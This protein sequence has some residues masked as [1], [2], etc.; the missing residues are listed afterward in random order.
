MS[1]EMPLATIHIDDVPSA[2][3]E[4][5]SNA[6]EDSSTFFKLQV[7]IVMREQPEDKDQRSLCADHS[8]K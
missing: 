4:H 2:R 6:L 1:G 5:S 7:R 3:K 8:T